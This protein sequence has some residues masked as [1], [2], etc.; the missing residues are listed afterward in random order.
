MGVDLP[1]SVRLSKRV[2]LDALEYLDDLFAAGPDAP[3]SVLAG[4]A[5]GSADSS[6]MPFRFCSTCPLWNV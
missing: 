4:A 3:G 2:T 6:E 1:L 5:E